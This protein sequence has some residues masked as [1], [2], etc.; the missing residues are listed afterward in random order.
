V[1][2]IILVSYTTIVLDI[3]IVITA[4]PK[5]HYALGFFL[6][7]PVLGAERV[8]ARTRNLGRNIECR[9]PRDIPLN[10]RIE[11]QSKVEMQRLEVPGLRAVERW[12][13]KVTK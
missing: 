9:I 4:L 5:I 2:V 13:D 11:R 7:R 1:L 6:H 8:T 10:L 12:D 3:S